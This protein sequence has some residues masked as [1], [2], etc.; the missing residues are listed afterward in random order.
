MNVFLLHNDEVL[1][2]GHTINQGS[3]NIIVVYVALPTTKENG[4]VFSV[5]WRR[6]L[7]GDSAGAVDEL[8]FSET[9]WGCDLQGSSLLDQ[10]DTTVAQILHP[11]LDLETNLKKKKSHRWLNKKEKIFKKWSAWGHSQVHTPPQAPLCEPPV[12]S[13]RPTDRSLQSPER[14]EP[15]SHQGRSLI[16]SSEKKQKQNT[17]SEINPKTKA[18]KRQSLQG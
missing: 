18:Q 7:F 1:Y 15:P 11:G 10:R 13:G 17:L 14:P 16:W 6:Y 12:D 2:K 8:S 4:F 9:V 3:L 5:R